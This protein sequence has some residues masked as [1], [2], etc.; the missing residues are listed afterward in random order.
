MQH[1]DPNTQPRIVF[2]GHTES[3]RH[4]SAELITYEDGGK[5]HCGVVV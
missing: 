5:E 3:K 4:G 2:A 1:P